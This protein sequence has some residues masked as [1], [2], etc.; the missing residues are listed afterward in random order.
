MNQHYWVVKD[1]FLAGEYPRNPDDET[2]F[3]KIA[4]LIEMGVAAFIDLT[5]EHEGL[6]PYSH[7]LNKFEGVSHERFPIRDISVPARKEITIAILDAIDNHIQDKRV[8]YVH[9]W[10]GVGRT[11]VI[12]GCW[13]ARHGLQGQ[14]AL[15]KLRELWEASPKSAYRKTPETREQVQ[16][17]LDW[18]EPRWS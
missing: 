18:E 4:S 9:C 3:A 12:V 8:V 15:T 1:Q 16:Y 17:I 7:L 6:E 10:G 13:L 2:S 11:G 14:N 5:E